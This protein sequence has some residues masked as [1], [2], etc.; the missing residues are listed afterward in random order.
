MSARVPRVVEANLQRIVC[1]YDGYSENPYALGEFVMVREGQFP[2]FGVVVT[3]E[4]GP[5]DPSRGL[6]P[7]GEPGQTSAEVMEANPEIRLLL[8]TSIGVATC[9]YLAEGKPRGG[10]P[11]L[12]VPLLSGVEAATGEDLADFV[13]EAS[14]LEPLVTEPSTSDAA[15]AAAIRN[16]AMAL[17]P[18]GEAFKVRAGKELARLLRADPARLGTILRGVVT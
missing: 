18:P 9:G 15:I 16:G 10:L 7:R 2:T 12:P 3:S 14:F 1:A 5:E 6:Q 17:G 4:S 8:R 13:R 11:P